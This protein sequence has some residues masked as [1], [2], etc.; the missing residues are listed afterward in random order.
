MK[1]FAGCKTI[2][3]VKQRY[4]ELAKKLHP[5]CGGNAEDFKRMS[6]EYTEAFERYKNIH[7][8]AA[9][10]TYTKET[11]ETPERFAEIINRI[12]G[13][14]GIHIEI[15]GSWI[16]LTGSTLIYKDTIKAAGFWWSKT[17]QAWYWNGETT[18]T[19]RRGRYNMTQL[20]E[21]WGSQEITGDKEM[22]RTIYFDSQ[23]A[24]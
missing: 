12:I 10:E 5:D 7:I 2:E 13:L 8:N 17:K 22:H 3:D 24:H 1:Y 9:G 18:K 20:R 16:W 14:D 11:T 6:A 19:K 15:I 4:R 21:R 23:P